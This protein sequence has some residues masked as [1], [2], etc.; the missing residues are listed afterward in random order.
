M[1]HRR[2]LIT[3]GLL[4]ALFSAGYGVMFTMLD[5]FRDSYG[6]SASALGLIVAVGFF[7]S[8]FA[9]VFLAPRADRGHARQ[10]VYLG[11]LFNVAGL[12]GMAFGHN[13]TLLMLARIVMGIGAGMAAPAIRR[14]VILADPDHL[15][16]NIG[17]ILAADVAG[18]AA[19]P[20]I[21]AL[22]TKPFGIA[23]P[24]LVLAIAS[25]ACLPVITRIRVD[26]T[27]AADRPTTRFAFDLLRSRP[28]VGA[29]SLGAAVFLMVGTF[30]ALWVLVL[31]D[32]NTSDLIA[33]L[34][35]TLFAVPLAVLGPFG[36]RLAQ[37]LGPFRVGSVGL[38]VGAAMMFSYGRLP[39]GIAMFSVAMFHA[40]NDGITVSASGVAVGLV[41]P[42]DRQAGAQGLMGG[43]QTLAGGLAAI[44]ASS[45]YQSSGR[46]T[47]YTTCAVAMAALVVLGL[48]CAGRNWAAKPADET[49]DTPSSTPVL[50]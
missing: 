8:F 5:D 21:S 32:L 36:G 39:S 6:I 3:F 25:I 18:F 19:G 12:V 30:D 42:A 46:A 26:E 44:V 1:Q 20:A 29:I 43:V 48:A 14:I 49:V 17:R 16:Q 13:A 38:L 4:S 15:G 7:S 35:I 22:L 33:N 23:A 10:L 37:R 47:A 34:G 50:G 41:A 28:Y 40:V 11:M 9:Q 31:S 45:L 27:D 24:F 2:L